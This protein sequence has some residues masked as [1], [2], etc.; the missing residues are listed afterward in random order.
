MK[1]V[2]KSNDYE[3]IKLNR[4]TKAKGFKDFLHYDD[5]EQT[6]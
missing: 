6:N 3:I 2:L 5:D 4:K 1:I